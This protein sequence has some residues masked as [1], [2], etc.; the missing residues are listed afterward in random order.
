M[1][2]TL[3]SKACPYQ[4]R[5]ST[6]EGS[7]R[8]LQDNNSYFII[9]NYEDKDISILNFVCPFKCLFQLLPT[10]LSIIIFVH[11]VNKLNNFELS[12]FVSIT[13]MKQRTFNKQSDLVSIQ[14]IV[15]I[16]IVFLEN[17]SNCLL[18]LFSGIAQFVV[19]TVSFVL[20][21]FTVKSGKGTLVFVKGRV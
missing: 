12:W 8:D 9:K 13:H 18:N 15:V 20:H 19:L 7:G 21:E 17:E 5:G 4:G 10:K 11:R 1:S 14:E 16:F 6:W 2:Y 3:W